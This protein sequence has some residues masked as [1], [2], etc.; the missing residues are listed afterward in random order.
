MQGRDQCRDAE[1]WCAK[2]GWNAMFAL[3]STL[4][5]GQPSGGVAIL[6]SQRSDIGVTDPDLPVG[7][8]RH[9]LLGLRLSV[10]GLDP[11]IL[12]SAY[13]QADGG[14]NETNRELLAQTAQWQ[15]LAQQPLVVGGDF[16][17]KPDLVVRSGFPSRAEMIIRA[18]AGPSYRT[19]S[20]LRP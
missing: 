20:Q 18:P 13:W 15:E 14:M 10:P 3:A 2:R 4:P 9:R 5:S 17:V 12:V 6:V 8:W 11:F 7:E 16:N 19:A 1:E